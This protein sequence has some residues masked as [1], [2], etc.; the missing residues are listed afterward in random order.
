MTNLTYYGQSCFLI[1]HDGINILLDPFISG[2]EL[3]EHIDIDTIPADFILLSHGHQDHILDAEPIAKRTSAKIISTFEI[4]NWFAS[5]GIE[6]AHAMNHGGA[7]NFEFG[8]V[9]VVTAVHSSSLPDGSYGG[10][11]CGFVISLKNGP[12]L[13]YSGDTAL[14]YD[15][16]LIGDQYDLDLA[17]LCLG[18]NFTMGIEDAL[19]AAEFSGAHRIIGMHFDTFPPIKIDHDAAIS[20]FK[21]AGRDLSLMKIGESKDITY[22]TE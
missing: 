19:R 6:H 10:N 20:T 1:E 8:C 5:K 11:P 13:Y 15:M 3:A 16:K 21:N 12:T 22:Q 17:L 7:Y 14:T 2:N 9:K 4:V 18:D